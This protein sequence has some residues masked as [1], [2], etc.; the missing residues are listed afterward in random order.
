MEEKINEDEILEILGGDTGSDTQRFVL[1]RY[2]ITSTDPFC[3]A[4]P[5]DIKDDCAGKNGFNVADCKY[6]VNEIG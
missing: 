2:S 1:C 5:Q 3:Y 4:T 6:L